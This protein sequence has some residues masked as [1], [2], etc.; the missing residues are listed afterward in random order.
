MPQIRILKHPTD[1]DWML[2]KQVAL[3]TVGKDTVT[4]PTMEWKRKMLR[5]QHSP[6]RILPFLFELRDIPYYVSVHLCRHVHSVPFV[7]SQRNDRQSNYDRRKAPQDAPITMCWYM[8]AEEL[9][10]IAHKRL[11]GKASPETR[12]VVNAMCKAAE[13]YNPE[14]EG[15]LVPMCEYTHECYEIQS[16]ERWKENGG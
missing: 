8:S 10:T 3:A 4:P 12:I 6:I 2:C 15:L 5:A 14:F 13:R 7:Q 9:I 1:E 11:C 16:C